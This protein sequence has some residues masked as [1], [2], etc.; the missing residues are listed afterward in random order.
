MKV[1]SSHQNLWCTR[2]L[3]SRLAGFF[4]GKAMRSRMEA[5]DRNRLPQLFDHPSFGGDLYRL[6]EPVLDIPSLVD[7]LVK[8]QGRFCFST[9]NTT[10]ALDQDKPGRIIINSAAGTI[11]LQARRLIFTA[12]E[13]TTELLS[14]LGIDRP[15]AQLRPLHMV[16]VT[17]A[18]PEL[19]AHCLEGSANPRITITSHTLADGRQA[20]YLGGQ[21]A[22]R[23]VERDRQ[24]Q[25]KAAKS[26]LRAT[27]PWIDLDGTRWSTFRINRAEPKSRSGERP[28]SCSVHTTPAAIAAW[29]IKLAFA[30]RLAAKII[31]TLNGEKLLPGDA[32]IAALQALPQPPIA[33]PPWELEKQW[34]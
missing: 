24:E 19:Y 26:E 11:R 29:P 6:D 21:L 3:S 31:T 30:P 5:I 10:L 2:N 17:G 28:K 20:W 27:L 1:L 32:D 7:V 12:G 33:Q 4:A 9:D 22:E 25:I 15:T 23:G 14:K 34:S 13:G 16:M 8:Q 18:L